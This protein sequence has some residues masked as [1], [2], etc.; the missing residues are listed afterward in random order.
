MASAELTTGQ[1]ENLAKISKIS[2]EYMQT[3][4][5]RAHNVL[6]EMA[7]IVG[8]LAL[9]APEE[10]LDATEGEAVAS[11]NQAETYVAV[12]EALIEGP[13]SK[14]KDEKTGKFQI[15]IPITTKNTTIESFPETDRVNFLTG[16]YK[17]QYIGIVSKIEAMVESPHHAGLFIEAGHATQGFKATPV[18]L[19]AHPMSYKEK[20]TTTEQRFG[21]NEISDE[22][23]QGI[24]ITCAPYLADKTMLDKDLQE[25]KGK[26]AGL[27]SVLR[28]SPIN[29]MH[30]ALIGADANA[31]AE[32]GSDAVHLKSD[33][34]IA[35]KEALNEHLA[36]IVVFS[37]STDGCAIML[38]P[39]QELDNN[40]QPV[41]GGNPAFVNPLSSVAKGLKDPGVSIRICLKT[42][43][44]VLG[45]KEAMDE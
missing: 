24:I 17:D 37:P 19:V 25:L 10:G 31:Q 15:K 9:N 12:T 14:F 41:Q 26:Q 2:P 6:Q 3:M 35:A 29:L 18:T 4:Q 28:A 43:F 42:H 39:Y 1:R 7:K 45:L 33:A 22:Q 34:V 44:Q 23:M 32:N 13:V 38:R 8:D 5:S 11:A 20:K 16:K 40:S 27:F 21:T 30:N 36:N